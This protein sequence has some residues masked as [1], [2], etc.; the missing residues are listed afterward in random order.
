MAKRKPK[1]EPVTVRLKVAGES[2][3]LRIDPDEFSPIDELDLYQQSNKALT[4]RT[5][6]A[7]AFTNGSA[8]FVAGLLFLARR[9][10]GD[11]TANYYQILSGLSYA[12]AAEIEV[13]LV[14]HNAAEVDDP[15]A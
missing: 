2:Y 10:A 9:Q 4:I 8:I 5:V 7:E 13:E 14:D 1:D 11:R 3:D 6:F 12:D 15:E